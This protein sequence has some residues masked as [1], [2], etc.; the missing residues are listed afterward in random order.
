MH[1]PQN[2]QPDSSSEVPCD[3]PISTRSERSSSVSALSPRTSS[4]TRTQRAQTMHK[5]ISIS[6][7]G[8]LVASG[9]LRLL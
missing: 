2:S 1:A 3:V 8:S 9:M 5:F 7:Y 4:H 6:Q